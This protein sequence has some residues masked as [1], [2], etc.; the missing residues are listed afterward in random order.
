M[1]FPHALTLAEVA[2]MLGCTF[3]GPANL[4]VTGLNEIHRVEPGEVTFVDI[5][6]YYDKA[7]NSP[8]TIVLINQKITPP[9]GKGLLISDQPFQDFN[10]LGEWFRP[11]SDLSFH[12]SPHLGEGA[13]LGKGVVCGDNVSIGEGSQ[14]GHQV[15]IG[16]HVK[17]GAHC[18]IHP[19]VTIGDYSEIGDHVCINANTVIGGEAFYFKSYPDRKEK[20]I[21][22]G[23]VII[24]DHVDIGSNCSIDRGVTADTV[25]GEYTKLDNLIQV[26]HD[27]QIGKR[28][29][30][31]GQTGIAGVSTIEDDVVLLGKVGVVKDVV[32]GQGA[33]INSASN[34]GKSVPP[35]KVYAGWFAQEASK[36]FREI[37]S[38]RK[39]PDLIGQ[40]E[41]LLKKK[42][43]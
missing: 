28:C 41:Q 19:Q 26:G 42:A 7:L 13:K 22:R 1:K 16:S 3:A 32:I 11:E 17:I 40:L 31:A 6:K 36:T 38:L 5:E 8:A 39:L 9:A 24:Q 35:G 20:F 27:T 29:I 15:V 43:D 21:T 12:S 23:R 34:I 30:L 10:R 33:I 14:I 18:R 4:P 25:I 2:E 37:V